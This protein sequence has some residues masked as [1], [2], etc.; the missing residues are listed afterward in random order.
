MRCK[1]GT[2]KGESAK[3]VLKLSFEK[4]RSLQSALEAEHSAASDAGQALQALSEEMR[5]DAA[6]MTSRHDAELAELAAEKAAAL[7][8][9]ELLQRVHQDE[10]GA[11]PRGS[12][13]FVVG[14]GL[15]AGC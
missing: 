2:P 11:S 12:V 13:P 8:R 7:E 10:V 1:Q 5:A 3:V 15:L 6:A 14:R 4:I 9:V